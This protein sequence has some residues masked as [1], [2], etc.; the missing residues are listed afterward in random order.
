MANEEEFPIPVT[1]RDLSRHRFR[2]AQKVMIVFRQLIQIITL[3][4]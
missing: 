2:L 4:I 1:K 3:G